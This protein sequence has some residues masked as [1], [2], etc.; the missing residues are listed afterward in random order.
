M[1]F[2]SHC[3]DDWEFFDYGFIEKSIDVLNYD[4]KIININ[5][6]VRFD[7]ERGSMHPVSEKLFT[8]NNTEYRIY[9]YNYLGLWHGF[10]WNPGLRRK[11]DYDIIS[12]YKKFFNEQGVGKK[13]FEM[14][15]KSACLENFY[16]KHIGTNSITEKSNS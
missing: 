14:G 13:Y 12:P 15:Y 8:N 9:N 4:D 2:R 1:L 10:S 11:S 3:E 7:G 5:T 16:N 6:R